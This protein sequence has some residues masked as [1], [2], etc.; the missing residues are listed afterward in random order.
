M[1]TEKEYL[2]AVKVVKHYE[3]QTMMTAMNIR[4]SIKD[5]LFTKLKHFNLSVRTLNVLSMHMSDPEEQ[6]II[7]VHE[8]IGNKKDFRK[9]RNAGKKVEAELNTMFNT[10]G[11]TWN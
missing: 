5:A 3:L 6:T 8:Y 9:Y 7:S 1:I 10:I 4:G 11:I 2:E